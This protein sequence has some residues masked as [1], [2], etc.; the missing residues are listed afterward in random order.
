M[1]QWR[2]GTVQAWLEVVMAMP[3]YIRSCSEN[4]KSGKVGQSS[5]LSSAAPPLLLLLLLQLKLWR[6][7]GSTRTDR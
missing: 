1:S 5:R 4:V 6:F 2:A 7:A 3:M